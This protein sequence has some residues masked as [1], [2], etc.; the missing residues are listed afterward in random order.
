MYHVIFAFSSI[1]LDLK[2]IQKSL[3]NKRRQ[4]VNQVSI[5]TRRR[6]PTSSHQPQPGPSLRNR[7]L[8]SIS[9]PRP[10]RVATRT[11]PV[12]SPRQLQSNLWPPPVLIP[13][14]YLS[15][16]RYMQDSKDRSA[17]MHL[18]PTPMHLSTTVEDLPRNGRAPVH[19]MPPPRGPL[20][21]LKPEVQRPPLYQRQQGHLKGRLMCARPAPRPGVLVKGALSPK[22]Q[23]QPVQPP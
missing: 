12:M 8:A 5:A 11:D 14:Q 2:T 6:S 4:K 20:T 7:L 22:A 9:P 16:T 10:D 18:R 3:V 19:H 17:R 21:H 15:P 1:A 23:P 13:A